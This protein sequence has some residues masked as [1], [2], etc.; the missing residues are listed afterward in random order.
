MRRPQ[1]DATN[2]GNR[3]IFR[4]SLIAA[5][6][7]AVTFGIAPAG[8]AAT[9]EITREVRHAFATVQHFDPTQQGNLL[10]YHPLAGQS[11]GLILDILPAGEIIQ[12]IVAE[13]RSA[14]EP[15]HKLLA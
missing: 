7:L 1:P 2:H 15:S 5:I 4:Y 9:P 13:A 6:I 3:K 12:R 8:Y 10:L 14:L 11:A